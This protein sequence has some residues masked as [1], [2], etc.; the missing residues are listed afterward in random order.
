MKTQLL[1]KQSS[2]FIW[3]LL[4]LH[5]RSLHYTVFLVGDLW[6]Q[7]FLQRSERS[8][9]AVQSLH[10]HTLSQVWHQVGSFPM[11]LLHQGQHHCRCSRRAEL[12]WWILRNLLHFCKGLHCRHDAL[13]YLQ[14]LSVTHSYDVTSIWAIVPLHVLM[15][16]SRQHCSFHE[17]GCQITKQ[18]RNRC[19]WITWFQP[20]IPR[21]WPVAVF[22]VVS[23]SSFR[24]TC[25][26]E[27]SY[28]NMIS[29]EGVTV[30]LKAARSWAPRY[31]NDEEAQHYILYACLIGGYDSSIVRPYRLPGWWCL[32]SQDMHQ[33]PL[34]PW[35][36]C[37]Q[38]HQ[39]SSPYSCSY[40]NSIGRL[41]LHLSSL[42]CIQGSCSSKPSSRYCPHDWSPCP[43][44]LSPASAHIQSLISCKSNLMCTSRSIEK[45][46]SSWACKRVQ[47]IHSS[48]YY[49]WVRMG[50]WAS[51]VLTAYTIVN[52]ISRCLI[53][54]KAS[55]W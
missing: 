11:T 13:Q 2:T 5:S 38:P 7:T 37:P 40:E 33:L 41:R 22:F 29:N 49:L 12:C 44:V 34:C 21:S 30:L 28:Q 15:L 9:G 35:P 17:L 27:S 45:C 53:T 24:Y 46:N 39:L 25:L 43:G 8:A 20:P 26:H 51:M 18:S 1:S 31:H 32:S 23:L 54:S 50:V 14:Q 4:M 19:G 16:A 6:P 42:G 47:Q 3:H 55:Q 36:W 52:I 10:Q 48:P